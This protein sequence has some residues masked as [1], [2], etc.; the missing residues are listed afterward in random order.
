VGQFGANAH[1]EVLEAGR[2]PDCYLEPRAWPADTWAKV[3]VDPQ[4]AAGAVVAGWQRG[5]LSGLRLGADRRGGPGLGAPGHD[6]PARPSGHRPT[7][8]TPT[9]VPVAAADSHSVRRVRFQNFLDIGRGVRVPGDGST[10]AV[11]APRQ[12]RARCA[13]RLC[14]SCRP[15]RR[16]RLVVAVPTC[17]H[18]R[19]PAGHRSP[20]APALR[21]PSTAAGACGH[22]GSGRAGQPAA[23][24]SSTAALS[25][26]V[27]PQCAAPA[28][29]PA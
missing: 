18:R 25:D 3:G 29:T 23:E 16:S 14:W 15:G 9:P 20:H 19:W 26:G 8:R 12:R 4:A 27:G 28:S 17:G 1:G 22:C 2:V 24:P 6:L 7:V 11:A 10:A 13:A 5:D 21:T